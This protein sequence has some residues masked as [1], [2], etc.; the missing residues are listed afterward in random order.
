M[1][2]LLIKEASTQPIKMLAM[3]FLVYQSV[4]LSISQFLQFTTSQR[5]AFI[6]CRYC[7]LVMA[8]KLLLKC[9]I[10]WNSW[11]VKSN[12][13]TARVLLSAMVPCQQRV[14]FEAPQ[15]RERESKHAR[16]F[17]LKMREIK[18][19]EPAK[20]ADT[21]PQ[22]GL[23]SQ[24]FAPDN[25]PHAAYNVTHFSIPKQSANKRGSQP[26]NISK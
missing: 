24:C 11:L 4:C 15:G 21:L 10:K 25:V 7:R 13:I 5:L 12:S 9:C 26:L 1:L 23:P 17:T 18:G 20:A 22:A 14:W 2:T 3:S 19:K 6:P 8:V 16:T